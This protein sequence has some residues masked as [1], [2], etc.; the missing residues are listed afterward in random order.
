MQLINHFFDLENI[1]NNLNYTIY[2]FLDKRN[3]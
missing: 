1:Y 3:N 2:K